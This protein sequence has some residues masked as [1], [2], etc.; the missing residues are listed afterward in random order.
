MVE[1]RVNGKRDIQEKWRPRLHGWD[2]EKLYYWTKE[3]ET[4]VSD[5]PELMVQLEEVCR[6]YLERKTPKS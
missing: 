4:C 3:G 6:R 1:Q 2:D 5:I